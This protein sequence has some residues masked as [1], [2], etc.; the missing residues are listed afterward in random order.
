MTKYYWTSNKYSTVDDILDRILK[1]QIHD[2]TH[3]TTLGWYYFP[4]PCPELRFTEN[5]GPIETIRQQVYTYYHWKSDRKVMIINGASHLEWTIANVIHKNLQMIKNLMNHNTVATRSMMERAKLYAH[6]YITKHLQA[7][8]IQEALEG[9]YTASTPYGPTIFNINQTIV[10]Q[11]CGLQEREI[12]I[13]SRHCMACDKLV[14]PHGYIV[15][16][17][18]YWI[19]IFKDVLDTEYFRRTTSEIFV[20]ITSRLIGELENV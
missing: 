19:N 9:Q 4:I 11:N 18:K 2:M 10:C 12:S 17:D 6:P 8:K 13:F 3:G 1:L 15:I 5:Q 7:I 16:H 14:Q 20:Q